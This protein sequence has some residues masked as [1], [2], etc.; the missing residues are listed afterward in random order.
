M[1]IRV[2][3]L[4]YCTMC[5]IFRVYIV[6]IT[7]CVIWGSGGGCRY[8]RGYSIQADD[9]KN[10]SVF[11]KGYKGIDFTLGIR[12]KI[13]VINLNL[14]RKRERFVYHNKKQK[15]ELQQTDE[16]LT[17]RQ[18][19]TPLEQF[20]SCIIAVLGVWNYHERFRG[21]WRFSQIFWEGMNILPTN[22]IFPP[23]ASSMLYC[24]WS[25]N[26]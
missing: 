2:Q 23:P 1:N 13:Q 10:N 6:F 12:E 20:C 14:R 5:S 9:T 4:I 18:S 24:D 8:G 7:I 11:F 3:I 22:I 19:L 21:V 26:Y 16:C 15:T 25:L 17:I